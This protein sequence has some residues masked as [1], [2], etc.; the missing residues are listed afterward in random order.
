[1]T[2]IK[3]NPNIG[4]SHSI[5]SALLENSRKCYQ[6]GKCFAGCPMAFAMDISP[7]QVMRFIQLGYLDEV[8]C[9]KTIWVCSSCQTCTTRCPQEVEIAHVMDMLRSLS[10]RNSKNTIASEIKLAHE[11]FLKNIKMFGRVFEPLLILFYNFRSGQ[12]FKDVDKAPQMLFEGNLT[13]FPE[14]I[15]GIKEVRK[16]FSNIEKLREKEP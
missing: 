9:S 1:M 11:L 7:S 3:T 12:F 6:C 2:E 16:I 15:K 4:Y 10:F 8:L 5:M 13:F 14:T